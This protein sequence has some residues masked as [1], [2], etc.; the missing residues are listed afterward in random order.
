MG[1]YEFRDYSN[2]MEFIN[3]EFYVVLVIFKP[4]WEYCLALM[5]AKENL[6]FF[7]KENALEKLVRKNKNRKMISIRI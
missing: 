5:N 6:I 1:H 7:N 3:S 2:F 4:D